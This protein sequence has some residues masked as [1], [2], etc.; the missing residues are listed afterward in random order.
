MSLTITLTHILQNKL[1]SILDLDQGTLT[2]HDVNADKQPLLGAFKFT[3]TITIKNATDDELGNK[4]PEF[5]IDAI[6]HEAVEC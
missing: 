5:T 4:M 3:A 2:F 6:Q 1:T